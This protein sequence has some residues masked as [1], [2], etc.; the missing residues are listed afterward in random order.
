M[1]DDFGTGYSSLSHLK[2]FPIDVKVSRLGNPLIN[3]V[4]IPIGQKDKFNATSPANDA[5]NFGAT[6]L[7]PEP[8]KLLN[9]LFGLGVKETGRTDIVRRCS[10]AC[11]GLTQIGKQR[12]PRPTR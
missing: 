1:L 7:A 11:P 8:A 10:P 2:R 9:A 5:A 3:E 12:R 4:I 6:A